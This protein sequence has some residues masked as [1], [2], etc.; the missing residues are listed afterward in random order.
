M[1]RQAGLQVLP[2]NP[3][4]RGVGTLE[5]GDDLVGQALAGLVVGG[6]AEC[7]QVGLEYGADLVRNL[8]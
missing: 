8:P 4:G 7:L 2:E 1:I 3:H 5:A 6:V